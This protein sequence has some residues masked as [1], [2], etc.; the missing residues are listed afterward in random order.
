MNG[1][2]SI[3]PAAELVLG[4]EP[5]GEEAVTP[6]VPQ[7]PPHRVRGVPGGDGVRRD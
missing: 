2:F 6:P 3:K 5:G 4:V 1:G 7:D